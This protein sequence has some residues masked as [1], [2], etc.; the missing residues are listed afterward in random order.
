M[1]LKIIIPP[2]ITVLL[3]V[4]ALNLLLITS[5]FLQILNILWW[6][7]HFLFS[8]FLQQYHLSVNCIRKFGGHASSVFLSNEKHVSSFS[9]FLCLPAHVVSQI[10]IMTQMSTCITKS[11]ENFYSASTIDVLSSHIVIIQSAVFVVMFWIR[12][13]PKQTHN[14]MALQSAEGL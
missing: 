4:M 13:S 8:Q 12:Q 14:C 1:G 5:H 9:I 7:Y 2:G 3:T 11:V 10:S 6:F